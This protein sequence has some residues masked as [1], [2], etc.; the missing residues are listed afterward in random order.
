MTHKWILIFQIPVRQKA[1]YLKACEIKKPVSTDGGGKRNHKVN[2]NNRQCF[3]ICAYSQRSTP[4]VT[5]TL[6]YPSLWGTRHCMTSLPWA[7]STTRSSTTLTAQANKKFPDSPG[8]RRD[9]R[10]ST[11]W[12]AHSP[13][14]AS[15]CGS[16]STLTS[17]LN[18]WDRITRVR[19]K[20][21]KGPL[22]RMFYLPID[23]RT[24]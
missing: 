5:S 20:D 1:F 10:R 21:Y 2:K 4:W 11:G 23:E 22:I 3:S 24:S 17:W 6:P 14:I 9:S 7:C 19:S 13:A 16:R 15:S 12:K 8:W 18:E